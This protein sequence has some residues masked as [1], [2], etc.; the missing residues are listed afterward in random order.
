M[1]RVESSPEAAHS[2]HA[3]LAKVKQG[4]ITKRTPAMLAARESC[5]TKLGN[6]GNPG[7]A[8]A[9][10]RVDQVGRMLL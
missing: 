10:A 5:G 9:D 6:R 4:A 2:P 1:E 7:F 8:A 3:G